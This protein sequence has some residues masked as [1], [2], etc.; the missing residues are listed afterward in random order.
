MSPLS[1]GFLIEVE[2][3]PWETHKLVYQDFISTSLSIL[4]L[5]LL[6]D[7][8]LYPLN[9]PLLSA[10]TLQHKRLSRKRSHGHIW[11]WTVLG[12]LTSGVKLTG[13]IKLTQFTKSNSP[14]HT[15]VMLLVL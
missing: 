6:P 15:Q 10:F 12:E 7:H 4:Y 2:T 5:P 1:P 3:S 8:T 13:H 9:Y 11:T 14:H